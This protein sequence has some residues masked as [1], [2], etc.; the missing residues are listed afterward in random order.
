MKYSLVSEQMPDKQEILEELKRL[1]SAEESD[2][3][4]WYGKEIWD[5]EHDAELISFISSRMHKCTV[6]LIRGIEGNFEEWKL[7]AILK[8]HLQSFRRSDYDTEDAE[9]ITECFEVLAYI[10]KIRFGSTLMRWLYGTPLWL[11]LKIGRLI[12]PERTIAVKKQQCRNCGAELKIELMNVTDY[13]RDSVWIIGRC[14]KC[15][16][17]NLLESFPN[18]KR[19]RFHNFYPTDHLDKD[20]F[21]EEQAKTRL[22]QIQYWR[23]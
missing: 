8:S 10:I 1:I 21:T 3:D 16:E 4:S 11:L 18:S 9:F 15:N 2:K 14:M 13:N 23:K 7:K 20:E 12:K 19:I 5:H 22:E 17:F 6:E